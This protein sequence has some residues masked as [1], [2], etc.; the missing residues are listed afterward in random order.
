MKSED[1]DTHTFERKK[2][3]RIGAC[4]EWWPHV[5]EKLHLPNNG[6]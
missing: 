2:I 1:M 6:I 5:K 4:A 3:N